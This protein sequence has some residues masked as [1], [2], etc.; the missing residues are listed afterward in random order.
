M[1]LILLLINTLDTWYDL[2][3]PNGYDMTG[4]KRGFYYSLSHP[5]PIHDM[6][7]YEQDRNMAWCDLLGPTPTGSDMAGYHLSWLLL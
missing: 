1:L 4:Y 3:R 6:A 5:H 7:V 2:K